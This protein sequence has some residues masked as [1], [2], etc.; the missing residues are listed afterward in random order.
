MKLK[1]AVL[2]ALS[3]AAFNA[4]ACF[5]L[6]DRNA[7][8]IYQGLTTPIDMRPQFHQV[9]DRT[10][11]GAHLVFDDSNICTPVALQGATVVQT[12]QVVATGTRAKPDRN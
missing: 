4:S 12:S 1:I 2:C 8:V 5:T 11:P 3:F 6:Y 10:H 9:L 7:R